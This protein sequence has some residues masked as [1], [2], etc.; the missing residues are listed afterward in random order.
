MASPQQDEIFWGHHDQAKCILF[1][2]S[3]PRGGYVAK[4]SYRMKFFVLIML[5][6]LTKK[7]LSSDFRYVAPSGEESGSLVKK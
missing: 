1:S 2:T 6:K 7:F 5:Q 3:E 4:V